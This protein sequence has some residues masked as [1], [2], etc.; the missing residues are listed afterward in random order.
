MANGIL[1]L[2]GVSLAAAI[3]EM[4]LPGAESAGSRRALRAL[5]ALT[6]LLL[7]LRPVVGFISS[8][9]AFLQGSIDGVRNDTH[10]VVF[11]Y[12]GVDPDRL[13]EGLGRLAE[14]IEKDKGSVV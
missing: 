12:S 1:A 2:F 8:E 4:L 13:R 6:V 9:D 3:G 7:I 10:T 5:V 14:L 11:N